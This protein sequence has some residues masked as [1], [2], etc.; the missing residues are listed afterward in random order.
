MNK[1]L[2]DKIQ[3]T[4][5][6]DPVVRKQLGRLIKAVP[7]S[8]ASFVVILCVTLST[9]SSPIILAIACA[10]FVVAS[11]QEFE[12]VRKA[13][14]RAMEIVNKMLAEQK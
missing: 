12:S 11:I 4:I 13:Y 14:K 5:N 3:Q 8:V 9:D 7:F 10:T 1:D 6:D 2:V